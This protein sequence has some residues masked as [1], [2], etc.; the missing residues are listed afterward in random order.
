MCQ[1]ISGV[2]GR[3]EVPFGE[4]GGALDG[5]CSDVYC[6]PLYFMC[7]PTNNEVVSTLSQSVI[8]FK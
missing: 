4:G 5:S 7:F 2:V 8:Q 1:Q 6:C 3:T